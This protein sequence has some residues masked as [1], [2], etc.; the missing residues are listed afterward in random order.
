MVSNL[1]KDYQGYLDNSPL[2]HLPKMTKPILM[3]LGQNDTNV[4]P[5]QSRAFFI[6]LKRLGKKGILI[7]Y[8]K[9]GHSM[10]LKGNQYDLNLKGW[11][12]MDYHLKDN[13]PAEWIKPMLE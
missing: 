5:D 1:F 12:W 7:E 2:Y 10:N 3:W 6:G 4:N 8:P 11:Q 9:E 13:Q